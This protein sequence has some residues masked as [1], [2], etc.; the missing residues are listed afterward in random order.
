MF[1]F[2]IAFMVPLKCNYYSTPTG[3]RRIVM[4]MSCVFMYFF[5]A[6]V[7]PMFTNFCVPVTHGRGSVLLWRRSG[8]LRTSGF[9]YDVIFAHKPQVT[10]SLWLCINGA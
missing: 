5:V 1:R 7:R 2:Y 6:I 8:M 4:T 10:H 9:M 3:E